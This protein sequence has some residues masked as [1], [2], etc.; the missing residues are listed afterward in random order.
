[1]IPSLLYSAGTW[2]EVTRAAVDKLNSLRR[3]FVR[4]VLNVGPG[5]APCHIPV[6]GCGH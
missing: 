1:M 5:S 3:W 6:F 4:L 2:V